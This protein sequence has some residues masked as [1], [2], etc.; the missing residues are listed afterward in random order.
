MWPS[1]TPDAQLPDVLLVMAHQHLVLEVAFRKQECSLQILDPPKRVSGLLNPKGTH[2][3]SLLKDQDWGSEV[4]G[5]FQTKC[6]LSSAPQNH[7]MKHLGEAAPLFQQ[8]KRL[9]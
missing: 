1:D 2:K 9:Q 7:P 5:Y 4:I 6:S 8:Q 3:K